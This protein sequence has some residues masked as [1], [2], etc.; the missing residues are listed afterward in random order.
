LGTATVQARI[1]AEDA[2]GQIERRPK[3]QS[4]YQSLEFRGALLPAALELR[5]RRKDPNRRAG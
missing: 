4:A 1:E 3:S 5:L 2:A